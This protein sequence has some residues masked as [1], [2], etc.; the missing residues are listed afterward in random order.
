MP[1]FEIPD[2]PPKAQLKQE[3]EGDQTF[4]T[5]AAAFFAWIVSV[6]F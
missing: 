1:S 5:G 3:V 6:G 4:S 2:I